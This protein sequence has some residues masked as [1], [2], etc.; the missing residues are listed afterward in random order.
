MGRNW[1]DFISGLKDNSGKLAKDELKSLIT[2]A[3]NEDVD[4]IKKQGEDLERYLTQ[5]ANGQITKQQF[6]GYIR[7]MKRLAR[8]EALQGSV[9]AK[10]AAQRL[11]DGIQ[12]LIIDGLLALI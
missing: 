12:S 1:Q 9:A 6:D 5:L 10:A 2:W 11:A 7:D 3:V 8:M 4:F